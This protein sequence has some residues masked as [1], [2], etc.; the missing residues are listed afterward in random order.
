MPVQVVPGPVVGPGG[1]GVGVTHGVLNVL[2]GHAGAE[3]LGREGVLEAM[4][5]DSIGRR[6]AGATGEAADEL[7]GDRVAEAPVPSAL[8]KS[9]PVVR[10]PT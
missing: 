9:G 8:R 7:V 5:A 3:Q 10:S 2:Q 6:D 4:G 1:P